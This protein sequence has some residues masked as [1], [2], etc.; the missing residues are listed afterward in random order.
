MP[1]KL[2]GDISQEDFDKAQSY[3]LK[4]L[5]FQMV[6]NTIKTVQILVF[7]GL[8]LPAWFWKLTSE[9]LDT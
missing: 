1:Q 9:W 2:K 7:W 6:N 4:K 8:F 5:E 3:Q